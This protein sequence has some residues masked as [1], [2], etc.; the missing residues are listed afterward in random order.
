MVE[1]GATGVKQLIHL[2]MNGSNDLRMT[3]P[4]IANGDAGSE[5]KEYVAIKIFYP[6]SV[7]LVKDQRVLSRK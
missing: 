4:G 3:M 5:I 7:S 6:N 2:L 1:I